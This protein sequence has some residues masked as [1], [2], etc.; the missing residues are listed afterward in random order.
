[1]PTQEDVD[2][3]RRKGLDSARIRYMTLSLLLIAAHVGGFQLSDEL[4]VLG[5]ELA[6][7]ARPQ[8]VYAML[9]VALF[10]LSFVY[11][12]HYRESPDRNHERPFV[13][14]R[15]RNKILAYLL[16]DKDSGDQQRFREV[17]VGHDLKTAEYRLHEKPDPGS[18][19][20]TCEVDATLVR[21]YRWQARKHMI[22]SKPE[23]IALRLPFLLAAA[24]LISAIVDVWLAR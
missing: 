23:V 15:V 3:G 18:P 2:T 24:A 1:L 19:Y 9:W 11:W 16:A 7:A 12:Q 6:S 8:L 10:W 22:F 13:R 14:D 21:K 5:L 4:H 17:K 20:R